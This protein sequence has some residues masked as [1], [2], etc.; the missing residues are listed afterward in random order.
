M[1]SN[2]QSCHFIQTRKVETCALLQLQLSYGHNCIMETSSLFPG[3]CLS[4]DC[5]HI[6]PHLSSISS[7][8]TKQIGTV[9]IYTCYWH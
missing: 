4:T 2:D 9:G 8:T 6:Y 3:V 5:T 7:F 1:L